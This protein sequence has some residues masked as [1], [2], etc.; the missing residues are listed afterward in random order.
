VEGRVALETDG[1][2][3]GTS[4]GATLIDSDNQGERLL[5]ALALQDRIHTNIIELFEHS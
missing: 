4:T 1:T 5:S 2:S 3:T